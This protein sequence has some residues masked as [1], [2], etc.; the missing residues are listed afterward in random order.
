M[1]VLPHAYDPDIW[2]IQ[3][4]STSNQRGGGK[5]KI[6]I[7]YVGALYGKRSPVSFFDALC[8][9]HKTV[10]ELLKN[11]S[12]EFIGSMDAEFREALAFQQLPDN[13]LNLHEPV[14]YLESLQLMQSADALLVIDAPSKKSIFLPSKLVDYIGVG[15]PIF[16]L[17]SPGTAHALISAYGGRCCEPDQV[18]EIV[19]ELRNFLTELEQKSKPNKKIN[20]EV[21]SRYR[22]DKV[23]EKLQSYLN[24]V[25]SESIE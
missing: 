18:Q 8:E 21:R 10:P 16:A 20:E 5:D 14:S 7:R 25:L 15:R 22:V 13:L 4:H 9:L 2:K 12:F 24:E 6:I 17:S 19:S 3:E 1:R 23:G 11:V